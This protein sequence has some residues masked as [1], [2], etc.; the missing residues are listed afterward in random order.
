MRGTLAIAVIL[1]LGLGCGRVDGTRPVDAAAI[2]TPAI[3]TPPA[4]KPTPLLIGGTDVAEQGWTVIMNGPATLTNGADFVELTT[5]TT[6]NAGGQLLLSRPS[7]V[8]TTDP[9]KLAIVM[10]VLSVSPHQPDPL[11]AAVA[12]MPSFTPQ[13]GTT[14]ERAQMFSI[15]SGKISCADDKPS[16][17]VNLVDSAFHTY[18]LAV[19]AAHQMTLTIDDQTSPTLTRDAVATDGTIAIGDQTNDT[20]FDASMQIRSVTKLCP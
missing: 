10:K 17:S 18:T 19:D 5:T 2:D 20:G 7:V 9:F 13:F 8:S 4:C 14:P 11:D 6:G 12:I 16:A 3:D 1:S 15:E